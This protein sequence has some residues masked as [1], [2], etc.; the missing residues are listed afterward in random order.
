MKEREEEGRA[1]FVVEPNFGYKIREEKK[2]SVYEEITKASVNVI[3]ENIK[4]I[5]Y[6]SVE[7]MSCLEE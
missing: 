5:W 4:T 6:N 1:L 3:Q 7:Q 2:N